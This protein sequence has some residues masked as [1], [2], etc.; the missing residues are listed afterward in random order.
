MAADSG[1]VHTVVGTAANVNAVTHG[2]CAGACE[3]TDVL[4]T[5]ATK[6]ASKREETQGIKAKRHVAMRQGKRRALDKSNPMGRVP[7]EL[8]G[9]CDQD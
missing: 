4:A 2:C 6:G 9:E 5:R 8:P 3:E 7:G 1:L